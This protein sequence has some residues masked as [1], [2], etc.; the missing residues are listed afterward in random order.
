MINNNHNNSNSNSNDNNN[1]NNNN[2]N[3]N[4]NSKIEIHNGGI[5]SVRHLFENRGYHLHVTE[6]R[7]K[8][9]A[10]RISS[11][12]SQKDCDGIVCVGGDGL[13]HEVIN[14][15][16]SRSD[17]SIARHIPIGVIPAGTKNLLAVSLGITSLEQA[18]EIILRNS[19][20]YVDVLS[21][22]SVKQ[23]FLYPT[24][25]SYTNEHNNDYMVENNEAESNNVSH[26]ASGR[27]PMFNNTQFSKNS[28][29]AYNNEFNYPQK[30]TGEYQVVENWNC[31]QGS[32]EDHPDGMTFLIAG[33]CSHLSKD[34]KI[35]PY[36]H[37]SDGYIDLLISTQS[38]KK[39]LLPWIFTP[40]NKAGL[41]INYN[42]A[43]S[44]RDNWLIDVNQCIQY[45]KTKELIFKIGNFEIPLSIDGEL[46]DIRETF[47]FGCDTLKIETH[48]NWC[49]IFI[50]VNHPGMSGSFDI[51]SPTHTHIYGNRYER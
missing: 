19:I 46:T 48:K 47:G 27:N 11:Q 5:N 44:T 6:T 23:H 25:D 30:S 40:T 28:D 43:D 16:L 39:K 2:D 18:V 51:Y 42:L 41:E 8:N 37:I 15:L 13:L 31:V 45:Y 7:Y 26:D 50:F 21:I 4:N 36:S 12:L 22:S 3:N 33:K 32:T 35:F 1:N 49:A 9:D 29:I 24:K 34:F 20:H 14:G 10:Y 17:S 38:D